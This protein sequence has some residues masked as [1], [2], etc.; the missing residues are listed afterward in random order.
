MST[1]LAALLDADLVLTD[2]QAG[3]STDAIRRLGELLFRR[4]YVDERFVGA[5]LAREASF[6][7]GLATE[8]IPIALPHA[9]TEYVRTS[10][11]AIG[12]LRQPVAFQRM[13]APESRVEARAVF[14]LAISDAKAQVLALQQLADLFQDGVTLQRI[15]AARSGEQVCQA[16]LEGLRGLAAKSSG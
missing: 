15:A 16:M 11:V 9:E 14:M 1:E 2:M 3:D 8:G 13:D 5:A 4:G 7:T 10:K 12:V 6:P